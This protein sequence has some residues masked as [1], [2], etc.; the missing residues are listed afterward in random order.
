MMIYVC[1]NC[2]KILTTVY[3]TTTQTF[4]KTCIET[5]PSLGYTSSTYGDKYLTLALDEP[6]KK[7]SCPTCNG[8]E[9]SEIKLTKENFETVFKLIKEDKEQDAW[10]LLFDVLL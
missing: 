9:V 3:L 10:E 7:W 5:L 4:K 6:L 8:S 2:K 1:N